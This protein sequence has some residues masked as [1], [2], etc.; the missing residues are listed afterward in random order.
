MLLV[1]Q[2]DYPSQMKMKLLAAK[3]RGELMWVSADM[4]NNDEILECLQRLDPY[5]KSTVDESGLMSVAQFDAKD[6]ILSTI[7]DEVTARLT[8]S[9]KVFAEDILLDLVKKGE[10]QVCRSKI[11]T[12]VLYATTLQHLTG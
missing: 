3:V 12:H 11:A 2:V 9:A 1:H 4:A 6:P 7:D 5:L 10:L 8:W